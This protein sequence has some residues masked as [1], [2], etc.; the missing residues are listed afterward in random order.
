VPIYEFRCQECGKPFEVVE[1]ISRFKPARVRCP[2]CSSKKVERTWS[3]V[4]TVTTK[5]S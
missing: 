5:K 4:Y 2:R 1:S 3:R